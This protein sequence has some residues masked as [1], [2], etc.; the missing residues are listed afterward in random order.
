MKFQT[1]SGKIRK[2]KLILSA[3]FGQKA[4][5]VNVK[6]SFLNVND[7]IFLFLLFLEKNK[8]LTFHVNHLQSRVGISCQSSARQMRCFI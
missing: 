2:K 8:E 1:I 3:E 6:G 7:I 4:L 5:K